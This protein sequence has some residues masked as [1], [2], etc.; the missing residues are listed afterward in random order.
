[1]GANFPGLCL[2]VCKPRKKVSATCAAVSK[3]CSAMAIGSYRYAITHYYAG[4]KYTYRRIDIG[5]DS[6]VF[7]CVLRKLYFIAV[8][9]FPSTVWCAFEPWGSFWPSQ[10]LKNWGLWAHRNICSTSCQIYLF[11]FLLKGRQ[12][13]KKTRS[14]MISDKQLWCVFLPL[15]LSSHFFVS[16]KSS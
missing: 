2:I 9:K 4:K 10:L 6:G 11:K 12:V 7:T 1:M 3:I 14:V 15:Q 5:I 13:K 8:T 16:F